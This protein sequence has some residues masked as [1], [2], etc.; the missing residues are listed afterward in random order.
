VDEPCVSVPTGDDPSQL[1]GGFG[2]HMCGIESTVPLC[3]L[4]DET[5]LGF[6]GLPGGTPGKPSSYCA[7]TQAA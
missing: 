6:G 5:L 2:R 1:V 4:L 7:A 3:V